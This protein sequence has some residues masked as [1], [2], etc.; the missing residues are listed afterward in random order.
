M[1]KIFFAALTAI[2]LL[3]ASYAQAQTAGKLVYDRSVNPVIEIELG[4]IMSA[5]SFYI[6]NEKGEVIKKGSIRKNG[7]INVATSELK[8]GLY[9]FE[10]SGVKQDFEIK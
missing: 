2:A 4:N 9:R 8:S 5:T 3:T 10:I 1:K 7:K 6:K